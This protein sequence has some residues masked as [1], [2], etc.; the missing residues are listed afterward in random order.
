MSRILLS[1]LMSLPVLLAQYKIEAGGAP[2]SEVDA[3]VTATLLKQGF[4]LVGDG[5][6]IAEF[7]FRTSMPTGPK[8]AEDS[9]TMPDVP[10][11]SLLGV[12]KVS[13]NWTDR[14]GQT[15][16]A[17]TYTLRFS[18]YP[19]DGAHQGVA[20]QRDFLIPCLASEDKDPSA[21]PKFD[22][23]MNQ[24]RKASGIPHPLILSLWKEEPA[25]F[26]DGSFEKMGEHDWVYM[27]KI[28]NTPIALVLIG[29]AEG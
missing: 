15:V 7:W 12:M 4:R 28:G 19:P 8:A 10:H 5:G 11:G 20:P 16:K 29:K 6:P 26:K 17:G 22:D 25:N 3:A 23:L 18:Y 27:F 13:T 14:R 1:L 9:V 24:A 2:P 21:T